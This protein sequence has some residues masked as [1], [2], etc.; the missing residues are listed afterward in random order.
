M[1]L[2]FSLLVAIVFE[3]LDKCLTYIKSRVANKIYIS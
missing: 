2:T 1:K 3:L